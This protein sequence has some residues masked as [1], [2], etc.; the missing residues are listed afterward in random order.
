[1]GK[2]TYKASNSKILFIPF[3]LCVQTEQFLTI[4]N[5]AYHRAKIGGRGLLKVSNQQ[6]HGS[7]MSFLLT[8]NDQSHSLTHHK[9]TGK[10]W[11]AQMMCYF[12]ILQMRQWKS[13]KV[14][15]RGY[16]SNRVRI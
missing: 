3:H 6:F 7:Q 11:S 10:I 2:P 13:K 4:L 9:G 16:P 1:M 5:I 14:G 8:T 15:S 12:P